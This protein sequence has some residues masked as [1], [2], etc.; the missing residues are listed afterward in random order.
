MSVIGI[1][2]ISI[3]AAL[4]LFLLLS[5]VALLV[6]LSFTLKRQLA[7]AKAESERVYAETG[8]V[9]AVYQA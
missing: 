1:V 6:W 2:S 9:L 7:G 5:G 3:L 8:R 4:F